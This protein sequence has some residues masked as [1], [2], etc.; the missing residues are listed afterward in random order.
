[1]VG[2]RGSGPTTARVLAQTRVPDHPVLAAVNAGNP[3][4]VLEAE[5]DVRRAAGLPPFSALAL[6]SGT[7]API[8]AEGL[9]AAGDDPLVT[10]TLL[11]E[12]RFLIQAPEHR[13]LCD[14]LARVARPSGRGLR[15]EVDPQAL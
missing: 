6:V 9:R 5:A 2:A 1:L 4:P 8:Y 14:L 7:L 13:R 3:V 10:V 15:V 12:S 11:E